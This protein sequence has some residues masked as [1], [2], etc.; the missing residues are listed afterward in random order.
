MRCRYF[1]YRGKADWP[2]IETW[3]ESR[4]EPDPGIEQSVK[5]ILEEVRTG[6][7]QALVSFNRKFDCPDFSVQQLRVSEKTCTRSVEQVSREDLD[8]I[9]EAAENIRSFHQNQKERSW[10]SHDTPG[11]TAGQLINPVNRAGLYIPGGRSGETP[12]ISSLLMNAIPAQ[13]AGVKEIILTSP[14]GKDGSLNPLTLASAHLLGI[15]EVFAVGSAWAVG[16]LAYGTESIPRVDMI[17]GPGNIY[18][19]TAKRL[20]LSRTGIDMVAGPSEVVILADST[21]RPRWLAADLL[22]QAE[23]DPLASAVVISPDPGILK[24][25]ARELNHQLDVLPRKEIAA[26]SLEN[27]GALI[28]VPELTTG[29]AL[30]N[31]LAPEHLQLCIQDPWASI[32]AIQNAG[33]VFL[34]HYTP[35]SL[36]DYFAGPNHV[37]PTLGT[38]RFAS[39]LSVQHFCKKTSLIAADQ[40]YFARS[41]GKIARLARLEGLEAHARSAE[42]RN[43]I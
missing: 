29:L 7:D 26:Q 1:S 16:G 9:L 42:I 17:A 23:H 10:I 3:K 37:L 32:G 21:A 19:T 24:D 12:L 20:L 13:V 35:E 36:G 28:Q 5:D 30:A 4:Q 43:R 25:V 14:P 15:R 34:G 39:G 41:A 33:A 18:V 8:L 38:A 6:G 31:Q 27:F 11:L 40:D 22:S 2:A